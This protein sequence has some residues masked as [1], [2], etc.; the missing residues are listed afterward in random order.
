MKRSLA[1]FLIS[2][3]LA[4]AALPGAAAA[5][6]FT[7]GALKID[8]PWARATVA[9]TGGAFLSIANGGAADRLLKAESPVAE[10]VQI[11]TSIKEGDVMRMREVEGID[12]PAGETVKLQPGGYHIMLIGLKQPLKLGETF[13]LTL[14]FEKAGTI[15]VTVEIQKPGA[16]GG[17]HHH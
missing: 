10:T 2:L 9:K 14:T 16:M 6:D 4:A 3:G 5:H 15:D 13:P 7:L 8:H 1:A 11:H 17:S 12:L